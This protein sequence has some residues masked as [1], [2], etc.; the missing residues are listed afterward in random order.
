[1]EL[2]IAY[3]MWTKKKKR[4]NDTYLKRSKR[5]EHK[6]EEAVKWMERALAFARTL[7]TL[8]PKNVGHAKEKMMLD[9]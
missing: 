6:K 9:L 8:P 2:R 5:E 7:H 4:Q 3:C 1:M